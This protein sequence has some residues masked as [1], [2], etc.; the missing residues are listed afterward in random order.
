MVFFEEENFLT[1]MIKLNFS[2]VYSIPSA[3]CVLVKQSLLPQGCKDFLLC[4]L[5][6]VLSFTFRF[7]IYFILIFVYVAR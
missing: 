4:F 6:D 3:F 5:L 2:I 7:M 1:L